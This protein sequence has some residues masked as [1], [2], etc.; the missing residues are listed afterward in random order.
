M[1]VFTP[2]RF[3]RRSHCEPDTKSFTTARAELFTAE[4]PSFLRLL[5]P[6]GHEQ[7]G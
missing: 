6:F 2:R 5:P 3:E 1:T 7:L 4:P